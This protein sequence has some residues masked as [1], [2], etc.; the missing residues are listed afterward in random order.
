MWVTCQLDLS[1]ALARLGH[2]SYFVICHY[3]LTSS[4]VYSKGGHGRLNLGSCYDKLFSFKYY[5]RACPVSIATLNYISKTTIENKNRK[6][7]RNNKK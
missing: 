1:L 4:A 6:Y 3:K 5:A 7:L 2:F